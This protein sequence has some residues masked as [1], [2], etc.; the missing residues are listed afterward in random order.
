MGFMENNICVLLIEKETL[1]FDFQN[2]EQQND[3]VVLKAG[4]QH[5]SDTY[6]KGH[7][8]SEAEVEYAI[9]Y[10]EDELMSNKLLINTNEEL[11][12]KSQIAK[13]VFQK[14]ITFSKTLSRD[15]IER[16]F[17][18]LARAVVSKDSSDFLTLN[19]LD[20]AIVLLLREITHH[21]K[22]SQITFE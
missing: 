21:L 7:I 9:N 22:F 16:L 2:S 4:Y 15:E 19:S 17:N 12:V 1:T 6:L 11:I 8:P 3:E 14:Y 18:R 5:I 20:F 10:I 13:G